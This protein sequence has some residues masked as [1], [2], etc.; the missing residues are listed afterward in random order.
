[1]Y[2]LF[3]GNQIFAVSRQL[4]GCLLL[5]IFYFLGLALFRSASDVDLWLNRVS[6]VVGLGS[7][8]YVQ[9]L[10][11]ISFAQGT[12]YREQS[13]LVIYSGAVAV[14][15]WS[16]LLIRRR[17]AVWLPASL[18]IAIC[19]LSILLMGNRVAM[20]SFVGASG[21]ITILTMLRKRVL[22]LVL[23]FCLLPIGMGIAPYVMTRLTESRGLAGY[24]AGRFI[25]VLEEDHSYQGRVAQTAVVMDMVEKEPILGAGMGSEN[26]FILQSTQR[27]VKVASVDN[28]W[29]YLLL[30][31]GYVGLICFLILVGLFL[32]TGLSGL[33]EIRSPALRA[34]RTATIGI[35]MFALI[36]FLGGPTFFHFSVAPFFSTALAALAV[37]GEVREP[38]IEPATSA[39]D[40]AASDRVDQSHGANEPCL[41]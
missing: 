35:F 12:Y 17:M 25:F 10:W 36:S 40:S 18:L 34:N 37:L 2:G 4:F 7:L 30:K 24:I 6:W 38:S 8:W 3:A 33:G 1:L 23:T 31:M 41:S 22:A 14:I 27:R 21:V 9:K 20:G 39:I 13:Q 29:G 16:R 28:G 11:L 19:V 15:A 32:K 5:P 26:T